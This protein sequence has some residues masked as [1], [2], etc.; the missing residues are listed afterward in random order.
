MAWIHLFHGLTSL[1]VLKIY[2]TMFQGQQWSPISTVT[3]IWVSAYCKILYDT[4]QYQFLWSRSCPL[5]PLP[6]TAPSYHALISAH[7]PDLQ[8]YHI[9][10]PP[11]TSCGSTQRQSLQAKTVGKIQTLG[12][13]H[14]VHRL[15]NLKLKNY[16]KD[17]NFSFRCK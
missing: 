9:S 1:Y 14:Q 12:V 3:L 13:Q 16:K 11:D 6:H 17:K 8:G 10:C 7:M 15:H 2:H 5:P 4:A